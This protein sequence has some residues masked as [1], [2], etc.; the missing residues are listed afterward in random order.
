M[1]YNSYLDYRKNF[2]FPFQPIL[3]L[4]CRICE[5]GVPNPGSNRREGFW[6]ARE[7]TIPTDPVQGYRPARQKRATGF[8]DP[9][10]ILF[11]TMPG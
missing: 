11:L 9:E 5:E 2:R 3:A 7:R 4:P 6:N 8:L 1:P 10:R